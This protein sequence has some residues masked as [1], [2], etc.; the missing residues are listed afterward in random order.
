MIFQ[1]TLVLFM[2]VVGISKDSIFADAASTI[3]PPRNPRT[4]HPTTSNT[5]GD[6]NG[7]GM[8]S[9]LKN[10][11]VHIPNIDL[12][13]NHA[14]FALNS[15]L[16]SAEILKSLRRTKTN[17]RIIQRTLDHVGASYNIIQYSEKSSD[18]VRWVIS[19]PGSRNNK[20]MQQNM[21]NK[22]VL[23]DVI[24]MKVHRYHAQHII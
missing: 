10:G 17:V 16:P 4:L 24:N 7:L 21:D 12:L 13:V 11:D 15:Y 3:S 22:L 8:K 9:K 23:D 2:C 20:N 14:E 5:H 6:F 18:N 19:I 1:K